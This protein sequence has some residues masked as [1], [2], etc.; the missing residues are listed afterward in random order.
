M[1]FA[2]ILRMIEESMECEDGEIDRVGRLTEI[3]ARQYQQELSAGRRQ[4]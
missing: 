3:R 2:E 4:E 1:S